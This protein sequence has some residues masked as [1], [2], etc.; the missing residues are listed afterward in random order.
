[1]GAFSFFF[2]SFLL[3]ISFNF[4]P[5]LCRKAADRGSDEVTSTGREAMEI[6]NRGGG[7]TRAPSPEY[8]GDCQCNIPLNVSKLQYLYERDLSNNM[9]NGN[10]PM[11][12]FK[13]KNLTFLDLRFNNFKVWLRER[14]SI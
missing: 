2:A 4:H 7:T 11:E 5:G 13:A 12:V 14:Y 9:L 3:F 8:T 1:M 10:L 6:I